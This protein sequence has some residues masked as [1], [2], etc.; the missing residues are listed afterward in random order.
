MGVWV[1]SLFLIGA[2][3]P[4]LSI[5]DLNGR[6]QRPLRPD[7]TARILFFITPDCPIANSYAPEIQRI[8]QD[9]K[10]RGIG[11]SLVYVDPQLDAAGALKHRA[12][13]GYGEFPAIL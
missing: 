8:C 9:A 1:M 2:L 7:E 13:F 4:D 11:C 12:E 10:P 3:P 6:T 5:H